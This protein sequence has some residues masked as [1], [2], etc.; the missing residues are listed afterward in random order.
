MSIALARRILPASDEDRLDLIFEHAEELLWNEHGDEV[1]QFNRLV[2]LYPAMSPAGIDGGDDVR[3]TYKE[4]TVQVPVEHDREDNLRAVLALAGLTRQDLA[5][6]M[7]VD[8]DGN[9]EFA[10]LMLPP[11]QWTLLEEE[12]GAGTVGHCFLRV[13][14]SIDDLYDRLA[15]PEAPLP[16][17]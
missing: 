12:F 3:M 2:A 6:R 13:G 8:T 16:A 1:E 7:C 15:N 9:S 4:K 11:A 17:S 5:F 14:D 10:F